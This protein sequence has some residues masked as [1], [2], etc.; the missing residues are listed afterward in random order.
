MLSLQNEPSLNLS[1]N[2]PLT[3]WMN[4]INYIC[5]CIR[6]EKVHAGNIAILTLFLHFP[7]KRFKGSLATNTGVI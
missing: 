7:E 3:S 2:L 6:L 1:M 4:L 5:V